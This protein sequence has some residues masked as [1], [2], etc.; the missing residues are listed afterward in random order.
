[1]HP[2]VVCTVL[3]LKIEQVKTRMTKIKNLNAILGVNQCLPLIC[4]SVH[5]KKFYNSSRGSSTSSFPSFRKDRNTR[6]KAVSLKK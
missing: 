2:V 4:Q 5:N 6:K 1:M 3:P